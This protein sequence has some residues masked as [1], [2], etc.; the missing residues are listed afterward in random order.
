MNSSARSGE[1]SGGKLKILHHS[2]VGGRG[3]ATVTFFISSLARFSQPLFKKIIIIAGMTRDR[4]RWKK[5]KNDVLYF[6]S[7][8]NKWQKS[9]SKRRGEEQIHWIASSSS[10]F[11]I[12]SFFVCRLPPVSILMQSRAMEWRKKR[13]KKNLDKYFKQTR[14]KDV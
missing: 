13:R 1:N 4:A 10:Y 12:I 14:I 11:S 9:M 2:R 8:A 6:S 3:C 5:V 7:E